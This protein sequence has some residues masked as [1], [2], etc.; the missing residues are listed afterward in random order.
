[1]SFSSAAVTLLG[2]DGVL[3][4]TVIGTSPADPTLDMGVPFISSRAKRRDQVVAVDLGVRTTKAV[5]VQRQGDTFHLVNFAFADSPIFEKNS[6]PDV[7]SDHLKN[8][9]RA[10]GC[11]A[12]V[13]TLALGDG[14]TVFRQVEVPLMPI[15][16]LRRT[17]KFNAKAYLQQDFP[18]HAF[19]CHYVAGSLL[20]AKAAE[21]GKPA[22]GVQKQKAL[23]GG[24]RQETLDRVQAAFKTA[25]LVVDHVVPGSVGPVNSFEMAEPESFRSEVIAL[26]ELGFKSTAITI[27]DCGEIALNRVVAIGG[28]R[29]TSGLAEALGISYQEAENIKVGMA[30]EVAQDLE[31]LIH[32]LGRELRASID[33]FENHHDK[34]VGKVFLSG[35]SACGE[36]IVQSLQT[37]LMVPC[38][39]WVP[40]KGLQLAFSPDR[41][42]DLEQLA[43]KL[44]VAVGAAAAS[45]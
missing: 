38:Q 5:H 18:D 23:V 14:E 15:S 6:P 37:E 36:L 24:V 12:K 3:G 9:I 26:V 10:L 29:L 4:E 31:P 28:D 44:T 1:M 21:A 40:T 13:V 42:G 45:F 17:L 11:K 2:R 39:I 7:L 34:A 43:P 32:P 27:L 35:G 33:F 30:S 16:D 41:M 20:P 22:G 19:D 8:V 25:G